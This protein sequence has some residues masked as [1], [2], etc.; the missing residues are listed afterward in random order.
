V[1]TSGGASRPRDGRNRAPEQ[2]IAST[3]RLSGFD[4][5]NV[6]LAAIIEGPDNGRRAR[7]HGEHRPRTPF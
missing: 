1:I 2:K 6:A 7:A 3:V 4:H 5:R